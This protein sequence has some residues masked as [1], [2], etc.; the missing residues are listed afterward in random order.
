M[1]K[2]KHATAL[3]EVI[4]AKDKP[5]IARKPTGLTTPGWWFKGKANKPA[6]AKPAAPLTGQDAMAAARAELAAM[7]AATAFEPA[8]TPEPRVIERIVEVEKPVYIDR[9][10]PV[11]TRSFDLDDDMPLQ[12]D[13][14]NHEIKF[15]LSYLG[16]V[17]AGLVLIILV[18]MAFVFGRQS[19]DVSLADPSGVTGSTV[20]DTHTPAA[21]QQ[22][23]AA[24][25][26]PQPTATTPP[27]SNE[28]ESTRADAPVA[29]T[30]SPTLSSTPVE[31]S[32]AQAA[33]A[34]TDRQVGLHYV[35]VQSYPQIATAQKATDFLNARGISCTLIPGPPNWAPRGWYS[36][37]GTQ[38][39]DH[40][41]HNP[42]LDAYI[43]SIEDLA[44]DFAGNQRFNRFKPAPYKWTERSAAV[45]R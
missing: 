31:P 43:Q 7:N 44:T 15:R 28:V 14:A 27:V 42:E 45:T 12:L 5:G 10:V 22:M 2:G 19:G 17:A 35:I 1:A 4:H 26:T 36:V 40:I 21:G 23:M 8:P 11:P 20:G 37:I 16:A 39:F 34:S 13:P 24:V 38:S 6:A 29:P 41:Q 25:S 18:A 33:P 9:P 30:A 32:V 3:F